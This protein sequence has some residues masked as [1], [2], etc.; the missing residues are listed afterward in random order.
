MKLS[1]FSANDTRSQLYCCGVLV[2]TAVPLQLCAHLLRPLLR[3]AVPVR[4][5]LNQIQVAG[6]GVE[7]PRQQ[8]TGQAAA[9]AAAGPGLVFEMAW[10]RVDRHPH[11]MGETQKVV[12]IQEAE[13]SQEVG[14]LHLLQEDHTHC[15]GFPTQ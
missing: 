3:F 2:G 1:G 15:L 7:V 5:A 8:E 10:V 4:T 6:V 9:A 12:Q 11:L 13:Q 14:L